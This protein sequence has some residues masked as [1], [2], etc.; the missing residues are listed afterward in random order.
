MANKFFAIKLGED[1][2]TKEKIENKIYDW[3]WDEVK[4]FV[5]GVK[6][7]KYKGF[8]SKNQAELWL[9]NKEVEGK[10]EIELLA[11]KKRKKDIFYC[12]TDGSFNATVNNYSYGL[13]CIKNELIVKTDNGIGKNKDAA[14]MRQVAGE[15]LAVMK[16][17]AIAAELNEKHVVICYDYIGIEKFVSG[18]WKASNKHAKTYAN[19]V[20]NF[21][22]KCSEIK[23]E[24]AKVD[25]HTGDD[26]N[27]L[28]DGYAKLALGLTPDDIFFEK[29]EIYMPKIRKLR[30]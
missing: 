29:A 8:P 11:P 5:V 25:A 10:K 15:F 6:G 9:R 18:K 12:Y 14:K 28:A 3:P 1:P 23:I 17:L 13:V 24:F 2:W 16:A 22:K 30:C 20:N 21:K 19:W 7:A 4:Q 27:E 26:L